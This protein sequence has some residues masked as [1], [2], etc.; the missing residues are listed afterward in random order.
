MIM[1]TVTAYPGCLLQPQL[2]SDRPRHFP[3]CQLTYRQGDWVKLLQ[4]PQPR[5][6]TR[7]ELLCQ[8]STATWIARIPHH[9]E[10]VLDRSQFYC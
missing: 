5:T 9:G 2:K 6:R 1:A 7:A 4:G 10:I 8:E 3:C